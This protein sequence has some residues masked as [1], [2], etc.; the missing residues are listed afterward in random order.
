ML[1]TNELE[2][3]RLQA[4]AGLP[5]KLPQVCE[6]FPMTI[7]KILKMGV[8]RYNGLLGLLLLTETDIAENIKKKTGENVPLEN[9]D[10]LSYLLQS[11]DLNESFS[12][13]FKEAL[14]TFIKEDILLLPTINSIL[15]GPKTEK[16]LITSKNFRDF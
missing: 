1:S 13:D 3:I 15:I 8:S 7:G 14:A 12:L 5:S 10:P 16:R 11:A 2:D 4:F 6:V 9:I